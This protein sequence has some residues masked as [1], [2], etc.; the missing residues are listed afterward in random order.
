MLAKWWL[1]WRWWHFHSRQLVR[2]WCKKCVIGLH[3]TS[4]M[5][6][7]VWLWCMYFKFDGNMQATWFTQDLITLCAQNKCTPLVFADAKKFYK[8]FAN[9][10]LLSTLGNE[11]RWTYHKRRR[12]TGDFRKRWG[13]MVQGEMKFSSCFRIAICPSGL[14]CSYFRIR[15]KIIFSV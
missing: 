6:C 12:R 14:Y 8:F 10:L 15:S 7:I 11:C 9:L 3:H 5:C 4:Y 13:R 1:G 2:W